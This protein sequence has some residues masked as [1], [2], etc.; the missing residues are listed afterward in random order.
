MRRTCCDSQY[1]WIHLNLQILQSHLLDVLNRFSNLFFR[2]VVDVALLDVFKNPLLALVQKINKCQVLL[3]YFLSH[4]KL[5]NL[6]SVVIISQ[7]LRVLRLRQLLILSHH[8]GYFVSV[9][10]L[11]IP[12]QFSLLVV[13]HL[14]CVVLLL[15]PRELAFKRIL[16]FKVYFLLFL[17]RRF[18]SFLHL[19][20][21]K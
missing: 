20:Q 12:V 6:A 16:K 18:N 7:K 15:D 13:S 3:V 19:Y 8:V 4:T 2:Q 10:V 11:L 21:V 14:D 5:L 1:N 9:V 17:D